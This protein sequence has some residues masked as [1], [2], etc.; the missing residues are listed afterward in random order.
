M[1]VGARILIVEDEIM[2]SEAVARRL[3]K[4]GYEVV[5]QSLSGEEAIQKA[6]ET[7]PDLVLMDI[8]LKGDVDGIEAAELIRSSVGSPV[9]YMTA[10]SDSG[11]LERAKVT[12][13]YMARGKPRKHLGEEAFQAIAQRF[14]LLSD[15]LRLRILYALETGEMSVSDLVERTGGTQPNISKH[16]ALML[17]NGMVR[18]RRV[19]TSALYSVADTSIF[20][21]CDQVCGTIDRDLESRRK[22]FR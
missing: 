18:R 3:M 9:V 5:G 17:A 13:P 12:E 15:P 22:A 20:G 10:H 16:L 14:R 1:M 7:K 4:V 6:K 11:T 2:L 21:L 19:G 8:V